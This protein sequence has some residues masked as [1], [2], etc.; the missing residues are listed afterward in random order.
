MDRL[1]FSEIWLGALLIAIA[2]VGCG[3]PAGVDRAAAGQKLEEAKQAI[4]A[5]D[6]AGAMTLLQ[7][8]IDAQPTVWA[9]LER[10]KLNAKQ[11]KDQEALADCEE[12][13]KIHPDN[14][15][16]AWIKT[17][18]KKPAGKRFQTAAPTLRK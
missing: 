4:A 18:L 6:A 1:K 9:Y 17:E 13:I 8:S 10:A 16:V 5:G 14:R 12:I 3:A 7:A 2:C 15:D 11:G